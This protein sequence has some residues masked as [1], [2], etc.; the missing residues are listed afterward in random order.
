MPRAQGGFFKLKH[1]SS[2]GRPVYSKIGNFNTDDVMD[3]YDLRQLNEWLLTI[4]NS[5]NLIEV[6]LINNRKDLSAL[7]DM[8][9][10]RNFDSYLDKQSV[11]LNIERHKDFIRRKEIALRYQTIIKDTLETRIK[12]LEK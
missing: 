4:K 8:L 2:R 3:C 12:T 9:E 10:D 6:N 1:M 7:E 11:M 5:I